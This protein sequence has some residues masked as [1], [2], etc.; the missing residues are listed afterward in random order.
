MEAHIID[1]STSLG[2]QGAGDD[3]W[4]VSRIDV[5]AAIHQQADYSRGIGEDGRI[6]VNGLHHFHGDLGQGW[7]SIGIVT[8]EVGTGSAR[9]LSLPLL[10]RIKFAMPM[11]CYQ[12]KVMCRQRGAREILIKERGKGAIDEMLSRVMKDEKARAV[13]SQ[14]GDR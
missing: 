12:K 11:S 5:V 4:H 6:I 2:W 3:V 8:L 14:E 7:H 9:S 1:V 13:R 10:F